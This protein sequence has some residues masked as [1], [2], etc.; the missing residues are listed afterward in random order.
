MLDIQDWYLKTKM[1]NAKFP[2]ERLLDM[3]YIQNAVQKLGPF[4]VE[5]KDSKLAGC[6]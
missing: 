2:A 5:N 4:A 1:I 6:R 3:S